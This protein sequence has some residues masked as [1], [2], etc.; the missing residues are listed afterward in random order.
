MVFFGKTKSVSE[1]VK[2]AD[3]FLLMHAFLWQNIMIGSGSRLSDIWPLN[4]CAVA[5]GN[6]PGWVWESPS[7]LLRIYLRILSLVVKWPCSAE[8]KKV[9]NCF[10]IPHVSCSCTQGQLYLLLLLLWHT[11]KFFC[12]LTGIC[13]K[14][15]CYSDW[16]NKL[17][18]VFVPLSWC[19]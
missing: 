5:R 15:N 4:C 14:T 13:W 12:Q 7:F 6:H 10:S 19:C 8:K 9:W 18:A 11:S 1:Y 2:L 17:W 3:V 16:A